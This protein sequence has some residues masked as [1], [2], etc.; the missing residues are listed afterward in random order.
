[1]IVNLDK[2]TQ[3]NR[4]TKQHNTTQLAQDSYFSK[5]KTASGGIR[6]HNRQLARCTLLP[7]E[8]P[9][10]LSWLG[11]NHMYNTK[12]PKHLNQSITHQINQGTAFYQPDK[13]VNCTYTFSAVQHHYSSHSSDQY[14]TVYSL[15]QL[16]TKGYELLSLDSLQ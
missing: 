8:L 14:C 3:H 5:E 6:T 10:Q 9:R 15:P 13:Q 11:S 4:K 2:A 1:M 16:H 7:T 12:Q